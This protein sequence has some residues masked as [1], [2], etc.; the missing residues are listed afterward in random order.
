MIVQHPKGEGRSKAGCGEL[1]GFWILQSFCI[2]LR[3]AF[4]ADMVFLNALGQASA[5][6]APSPA[7]TS[8]STRTLAGQASSV[9][10]CVG[11]FSFISLVAS[12]N[13]KTPCLKAEKNMRYINQPKQMLSF[14]R[15]F[16][17]HEGGGWRG[18]LAI[19]LAST[20]EV[21]ILGLSDCTKD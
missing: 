21:S 11:W 5:F 19:R 10:S 9:S 6:L 7:Q 3:F 12:L 16:K 17:K 20:D 13:H 18:G 8:V 15:P 1:G 4:L 2:F 14:R